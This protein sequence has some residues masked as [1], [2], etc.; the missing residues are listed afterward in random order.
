[1]TIFIV[2]IKLF[3]F[4]LSEVVCVKSVFVY[5]CTLDVCA[6]LCTCVVGVRG[7]VGAAEGRRLRA[8]RGSVWSPP[9]EVLVVVCV[10]LCLCIAAL[11]SAEVS[12][13]C[14]EGMKCKPH[15]VEISGCHGNKC[16]VK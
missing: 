1:M 6:C 8:L 5:M 3:T 9:F 4:A 13:V 10:P 16:Y 7:L 11:F 14:V 15:V 2:L 12:P